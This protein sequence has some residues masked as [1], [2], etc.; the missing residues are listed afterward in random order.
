MGCKSYELNLQKVRKRLVFTVYFFKLQS[1]TLQSNPL[2]VIVYQFKKLEG[3][4]FYYNYKILGLLSGEKKKKKR[5]RIN[6][7]FWRVFTKKK[8]K[9]NRHDLL[10]LNEIAD[11]SNPYIFHGISASRFEIGF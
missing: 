6:N 8:Q 7:F 11:T 9:Q 1:Y 10:F 5:F 4:G 2:S 3:E